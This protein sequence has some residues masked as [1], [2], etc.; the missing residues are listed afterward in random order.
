[1]VIVGASWPGDGNSRATPRS[2]PG[3]VL[4]SLRKHAGVEVKVGERGLVGED[5]SVV[6]SALFEET[7]NRRG[8]SGE[9]SSYSNLTYFVDPS[10]VF[11]DERERSSDDERK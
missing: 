10:I 3:G 7:Q 6:E 4:T 9:I 8:R 2:L 1:M 11:Y 5:G